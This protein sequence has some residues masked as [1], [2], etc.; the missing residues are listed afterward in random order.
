MQ[1]STAPGADTA[2]HNT[3]QYPE[4]L[5]SAEGRALP[6]DERDRFSRQSDLIHQIAGIFESPTYSDSDKETRERVAELM[7]KM[8]D[9]GQPPKHLLGEL[10]PAMGLAGGLGGIGGEGGDGDCVIC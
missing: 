10:G 4:Y 9:A 2:C 1:P 7:Q 6:Q 5:S 8:Q 3:R